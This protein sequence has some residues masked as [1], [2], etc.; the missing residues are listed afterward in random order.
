MNFKLGLRIKKLL[1]SFGYDIRYYHPF[2]ETVVVPL[3]IKT[4]LDIGANDGQ[5]ATDMRRRF[6]DA[7]IYSFE[8]LQECFEKLSSLAAL[9]KNLTPLH[10][11]LG[12][13]NETR[14]IQKSTFNPSS[15]LLTMAALHKT[16]YPKSATNT[17]E[18]IEVKRL[19]DVSGTLTIE[20]PMLVKIDV[21]GFE[22]H[23]IQGGNDTLRR[24]AVIVVETS[25]FTL[26][27]GQALFN[28]IVEKLFALGFSY[29]GAYHTHYSKK[30]GRPMYEDSVFISEDT[31]ARL[32]Q[33]E[34]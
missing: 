4:I 29:Y 23:V 30:T 9:D 19:D 34:M 8:P 20:S 28:T 17:T 27:E 32:E 24:A 16:L 11:A 22:E 7:R 25:F 26:Y 31:R 21:Q 33:E 5:A 18:Q 2:Y 3:G 13:K 6:Q 1:N 10:Y 14:V 12:E 15:S